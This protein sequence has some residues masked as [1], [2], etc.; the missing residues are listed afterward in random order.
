MALISLQTISRLAITKHDFLKK[1]IIKLNPVE[2]RA[3]LRLEKK[4]RLI[5]VSSQDEHRELRI[6][7]AINCDLA[8][9]DFSSVLEVMDK[10]RPFFIYC[11][12]GN[13]VES[14]MKMM[15]EMGFRRV[16]ALSS[17]LQS[18]TGT[19]EMS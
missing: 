9:A 12:N 4:A 11:R 7:G 16:Y 1:V 2:F 3:K 17:G 10:S 15:D 13:R 18:W 5:D 6:P 8:S 14:A 19:L